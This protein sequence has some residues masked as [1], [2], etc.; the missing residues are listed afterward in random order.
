MSIKNPWPNIKDIEIN[1]NTTLSSS[2]IIEAL[3]PA[4]DVQVR[5]G[6]NML[7]NERAKDY[8]L[9]T[10]SSS[11]SGTNATGDYF[12][13]TAGSVLSGVSLFPWLEYKE[14][15]A[16]T[17][18]IKV[19]KNNTS[20]NTNMRIV[21]T[22]STSSYVVRTNTSSDPTDAETIA[23]VTDPSK[24]VEG[25]YGV[26]QSGT[27][28][29]YYDTLGFFEGSRTAAEYEP[30]ETDSIGNILKDRGII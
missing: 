10:I 3:Q 17:F 15:T 19:G 26:N 30:Y 29:V 4:L 12:T 7:D 11:A 6:S 23:F 21:Y 13:L 28:Y 24:T 14:N 18:I 27:T 16:Y 9:D 5:T 25:V 2:K 8:I 22:D 20:T 1:D